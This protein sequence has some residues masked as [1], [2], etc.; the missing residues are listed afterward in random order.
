M[1]QTSILAIITILFFSSCQKVIDVKLNNSTPRYVIEADLL[2]GTNSFKVHV[3]K[4]TDFFGT[5]PQQLVNDAIITLSDDSNNTVNIPLI[6]NGD[7][8]I[9]AYT[10][11]KGKTY[12]LAVKSGGN[13]FI[14]SSTLEGIIPIDSV[15][16]KYKDAEGAF[17]EE[18]YEVI[19][20][21]KDN[22][23]Q[24]NNYRLLLTKND[25][26]QNKPEDLYLF[27]DKY[28]DGKQVKLDFFERF[29]PNDTLKFEL[30]TMDEGVYAFYKT[31]YNILNNQS[32][33]A[34]ANP[35]SNFSG[36]ALGYFGAFSVSKAT[37]ILPSKP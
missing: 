17:F 28:N 33:P 15:T 10:A 24:K 19:A 35:I 37:V 1:K 30:R 31:L 8:A 23:V 2:E 34:P 7:Y 20:H 27:D 9:P 14:A 16:Y 11:Q 12:T 18:G 22:P 36:G 6:G 21:I 4:T 29:K 25:T 3:A 5:A 32:G 13:T 26:L